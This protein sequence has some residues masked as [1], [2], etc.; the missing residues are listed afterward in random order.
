MGTGFLDGVNAALVERGIDSPLAVGVYVTPVHEQVP[1]VE[2]AIRLLET[3][4][5]VYDIDI[6]T[7][8]LEDFAAEVR[9]HYEDLAARF[10]AASEAELPEDRMYM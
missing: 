2:A 7:E 8:P 3:I 4:R 10:N 6:D 1:D 9:Q 5:T